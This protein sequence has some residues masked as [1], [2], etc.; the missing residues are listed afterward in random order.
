MLV[1]LDFETYYDKDY[2][3]SKLSTSEYIRDSRFEPIS[4]SIKLGKNKAFCYLGKKAIT[5]ALSNIDWSK[6]ILLCHHTQF[7][8]LILSHHFGIVPGR[9]ADTLSMAR[10]LHPKSESAA[11]EAVAKHYGKTNKLPMPD[12]KGKHIFTADEEKAIIAYN[13]TDVEATYDIYEEMVRDFPVTEL[14]LIDIT[15]RMFCDPVLRV[16]MAL[17]EKELKEE[18]ERKA[19]AI[20]NSGVDLATL[21][22]NPKFVKQLESLGVDVPTKPSPSVEGKRI[23]AIAKSDEALQALLS[24]PHPQV[25]ALVEGRLAAKSTLGESRAQRMILRG[26]QG[27]LPIYL[28]Y[29][30]AHTFR[31]S[32]GDKFNPQNFKQAH[33]VGGKLREAIIAPPGYVLV[34]VDS[35]QIEVRV[36][37]WLAGEEWILD[38]FRNNRDLYC[39]FGTEAYGRQITKLDKEERFVSKTCVLLLGFNGGGPKLQVTVL[40][41]SINQ[42]MDPVRLPVEVCYGL[43][44]AY[45]AKCQKIT[46]LWMYM[47]DVGIGSMLSG[48]EHNY[49]CLDFSKGKVRL[50]SGLSLLYPGL[51]ADVTQKK[52]SHFF[53]NQDTDEK[54]DNASYLSSRFRT[55]LY[56]G[57]L[58]E[59][60]VQALA[61]IV[62]A[63]AMR[64]IAQDYR[65]VMMSHDE[66]VFLAP[67]NEGQEAYEWARTVMNSPPS[68]APDL[69]L[70]SE[71]GWDVC[72]S[73]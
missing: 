23:P 21:S 5:K 30:G 27:N 12:M 52:G 64:V 42:G 50:P 69:P 51:S 6:A 58:V 2:T 35:S 47:N 37:A 34:V 60:I 41:Q 45:R 66:V 48:V 3:L 44:N 16:D 10:A 33:K 24:H 46:K 43:V 40:N 49:K 65:V 55:K 54:I 7:D 18:Q 57:L 29:A 31:W 38:A 11:L 22:S 14:D 28:S 4:C 8:G 39:E 20:A 25:V 19:L 36:L 9:Y 13:N 59:N 15:C 63:D 56:G 53:K 62:V 32:G 1:T 70:A 26:Q 72:Y 68:W 71:G 17:A 61:R 67:E 73:K